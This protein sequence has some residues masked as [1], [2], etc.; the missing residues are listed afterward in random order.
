M[1]T[2][3]GLHCVIVAFPGHT[4]LLVQRYKSI[5]I[6]NNTFEKPYVSFDKC[7]L[8]RACAASFLSL[9]TPNDVWSVA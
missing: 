7:R 1:V 4:H 5:Y 9:E 3:V 8:R 2:W 6:Y